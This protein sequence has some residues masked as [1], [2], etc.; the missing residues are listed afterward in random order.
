MDSRASR[1]VTK[2]SLRRRCQLK[3]ADLL[4]ICSFWQAHKP[5]MPVIAAKFRITKALAWALI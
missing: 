1:E 2:S 4:A 5:S 3:A